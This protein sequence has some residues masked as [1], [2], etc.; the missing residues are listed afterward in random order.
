MSFGAQL[1][2]LGARGFDSLLF[3]DS[4]VIWSKDG[5]A[6]SAATLDD[7]LAVASS[8]LV[9]AMANRMPLS[10]AIACGEFFVESRETFFG[11]GLVAAV[12]AERAVKWVGVNVA[13]DTVR[14]AMSSARIE[15][16]VRDLA[17]RVRESDGA[18]LVNPFLYL[19][20]C[21]GESEAQLH[22]RLV[23]QDTMLL[24]E[25]HALRF[26]LDTIGAD[27]SSGR[28]VDAPAAKYLATVEFTRHVLGAQHFEMLSRVA[29]ALPDSSAWIESAY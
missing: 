25:L 12:D 19:T 16:G 29:M 24:A 27:A 2:D 3:S 13:A 1:Q 10:G 28:I 17:W 8:L 4:L 15:Q 21:S 14:A 11:K 9:S 6:V 26:L 18:L 5:R 20:R 23:G 22:A 7:L